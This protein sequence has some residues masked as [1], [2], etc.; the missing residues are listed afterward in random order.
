MSKCY[1]CCCASAG[2]V[3]ACITQLLGPA[4]RNRQACSLHPISS[5]LMSACGTGLEQGH[6]PSLPHV[7]V[8]IH[9]SLYRRPLQ[10]PA[11]TGKSF[12]SCA[13]AH[14]RASCR[15]VR[16]QERQHVLMACGFSTC[17]QRASCGNRIAKRRSLRSAAES[18]IMSQERRC[19]A[20]SM[21]GIKNQKQKKTSKKPE[22]RRHQAHH[23]QKIHS[24]QT[25]WQLWGIGL[26]SP[27]KKVRCHKRQRR[28][29]Q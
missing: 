14:L 10:L 17:M 20:A 28:D 3:R 5:W 15:G 19:N 1:A 2:S 23:S 8:C 21:S 13:S 6:L 7:C 27:Y 11:L 12:G 9:T 25:N 24:R 22:V 16:T 18:T 26:R 29:W 4:Q